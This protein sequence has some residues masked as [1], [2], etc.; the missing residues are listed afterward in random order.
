MPKHAGI[1]RATKFGYFPVS[2]AHFPE[3]LIE[4]AL[5]ACATATEVSSIQHTC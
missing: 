5:H 2:M 4:W 3:T 1:E